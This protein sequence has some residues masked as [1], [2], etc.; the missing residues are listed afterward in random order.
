M[1]AQLTDKLVA[2]RDGT[3]H[4]KITVQEVH[5]AQ[6]AAQAKA[7][8]ESNANTNA[9]TDAD[10][11]KLAG[12]EGSKFRGLFASEAAL[13]STGNPGDYADVDVGTGSNVV[14]YVW[15]DDDAQWVEQQGATPGETPASIKTKYEQNPDTNAYSD[16]DKAKVDNITVTQPV[17]LDAVAAASHDAVT[18]SGTTPLTLSGQAIGF[19]IDALPALA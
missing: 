14:R 7:K 1:A 4:G 17:D 2:K 19:D 10:K 15:D 3:G 6:T 9:F 5:D 18:L 8:Y 13:P 11:A 12:L 16:A